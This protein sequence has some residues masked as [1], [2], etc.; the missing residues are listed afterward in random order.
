[1]KYLQTLFFV[2]AFFFIG[3]SVNAQKENVSLEIN[4]ETTM[5]DLAT[6]KTQL[7][8]KG[9]YFQMQDLKFND[10]G[11]IEAISVTVNFN[12]GFKGSA[13][14]S[15]FNESKKIRIIRNYE[16]EGKEAFCIG[17]CN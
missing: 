3:S 7:L 4:H 2:C 15:E 6:I 16:K 13:K 9:A 5:A 10:E 12:D 8:E 17:D 14:V 1:M 11:T